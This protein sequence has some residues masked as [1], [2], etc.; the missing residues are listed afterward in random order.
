MTSPRPRR[1]AVASRSSAPFLLISALLL[2]TLLAQG[3]VETAPKKPKVKAKPK[4]PYALIVGT[5]WGPDDR[6]VYGV[7]VKIRRSKDKKA[8]WELQ[9][10]HHGEFAQRVP[11]GQADYVVW[12]DLKAFKPL[13][14]KALHA[15]KEV[16]VHTDN[17]ER[18]DVGLHLSK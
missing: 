18:I 14:G 9:S 5:V 11:A 3:Q 10:D 1:A 17:D 4:H 16:P 8:K 13:D 7:K 15:V 12:A 2:F 6:P